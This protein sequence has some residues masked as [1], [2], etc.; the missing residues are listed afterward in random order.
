MACPA[1]RGRSNIAART[2]NCGTI[3][4]PRAKAKFGLPPSARPCVAITVA[5]TSDRMLADKNRQRRHQRPKQCPPESCQDCQ[6]QRA[7]GE[8]PQHIRCDVHNPPRQIAAIAADL[9]PPALCSQVAYTAM[10]VEAR[11]L[12]HRW[13]QCYAVSPLGFSLSPTRAPARLATELSQSTGAIGSS[14]VRLVE[15]KP[16]ATAAAISGTA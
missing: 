5:V 10:L 4:R 7:A 15:M 9:V 8:L 1:A 13:A 3:Y 11:P 16:M 2:T 6:A 12:D 14:N